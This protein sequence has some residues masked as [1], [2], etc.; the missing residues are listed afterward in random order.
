MT[1]DGRCEVAVLRMLRKNGAGN[2]G[3]PVTRRKK[4]KPPVIPQIQFG[5]FLGRCPARQR[6]D[7]R[8][9]RFTGYVEAI[10]PCSPAGSARVHDTP[11]SA[12]ERLNRL[13]LEI[14]DCPWRQLERFPPF[15]LVNRFQH[16]WSRPDATVGDRRH[17]DR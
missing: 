16:V 7:L 4:G 11:Q 3:R 17:H 14:N 13:G 1:S 8:R 10:D 2:L 15:T 6:D 5:G 12:M 9:P